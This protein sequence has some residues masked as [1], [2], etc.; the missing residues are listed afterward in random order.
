MPDDALS[1]E[2][3]EQLQKLTSSSAL[4]AGRLFATHPRL[5]PHALRTAMR[6]AAVAV[7]DDPTLGWITSADTIRRVS[8]GAVMGADWGGLETFLSVFEESVKSTDAALEIG[9]GGG[10]VTRRLRPLVA[11]LDAVDVSKAIL[12]EARAVAPDVT[13]FTVAGFG[14]NLPQGRYD[15]VASHDVFVHF[16]LDECA[17]YFYNV[18]RALRSKGVFV[19]SV[20]TLDSQ[21][22]IEV[23]R[24]AISSSQGFGARR[25]RRFPSSVYETLLGTFGLEVTECRR[26]P[27]EEY[28]EDKPA[29]HL[30][31]V[32]RK[33]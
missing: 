26:T 25:A 15:S 6:G 28:P 10:R 3:Q 16:E 32:A 1:H 31:L 8:P 30:N 13:Y 33:N 7:R 9:C 19:F 11:R 18:A 21:A 29:T 27:E 23:Y 17:R 14:D 20:Y 12:D 24:A 4:T 22:D 5:V 2:E